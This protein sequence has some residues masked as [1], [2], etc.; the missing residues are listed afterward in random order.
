[1]WPCA[2]YARD[3]RQHKQTTTL[4]GPISVYDESVVAKVKEWIAVSKELLIELYQPHSGGG[5][6]WYLVT[7]FAKFHEMAAKVPSGAVLFILHQP[8]FLIRGV[9]DDDLIK[10]ALD[11]I[12]DGEWYTIAELKFYPAPLSYLGNGN[13]RTE[14]RADLGDCRGMVVCLGKEPD[15]PEQ[16]WVK[17]DDEDIIIARKL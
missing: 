1:M 11:E 6:T 4:M 8:Q 12:Q 14:L 5:G 16:Y 15:L 9:V 10:R 13:S 17:N 2:A 3:V 7:S